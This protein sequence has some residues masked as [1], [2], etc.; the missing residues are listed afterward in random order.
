MANSTVKDAFK[1]ILKNKKRG[2]EIG[3]PSPSMDLVYAIDIPID[4]INHQSN[5]WQ[6]SIKQT[7]YK[8]GGKQY[9]GDGLQL[10]QEAKDYDF[11]LN[12]HVLEHIANPLKALFHWKERLLSGGVLILVLPKKELCFDHKR[13]IT[14]LETLVDKYERN[15]GEDD[16][17]SLDEILKLHDLAMDPPAG[18]YK[19]FKK[20]SLDNFNNRC[21]HHHVF[22]LNLLERVAKFIDMQVKFKWVN[23]I[24]QYIILEKK[25]I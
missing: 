11:I 17:S 15:V 21:L 8:N 18:T 16:L 12:A 7:I 2:L 20:R 13:N 22:D 5:V 19:Q 24:D 4:G 25:N 10:P 9:F 3:G 23:G 1:H 6:G 14:P